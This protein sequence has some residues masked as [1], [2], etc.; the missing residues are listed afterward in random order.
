LLPVSPGT[1]VHVN[2]TAGPSTTDPR[3]ACPVAAR[4]GLLAGA[5]DATPL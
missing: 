4:R 5:I 3:A 1:R 2:I